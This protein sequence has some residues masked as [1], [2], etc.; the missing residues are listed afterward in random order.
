[1][2]LEDG[3]QWREPG[4]AYARPRRFAVD[5][6][7]RQKRS[8]WILDA[9]RHI[10]ANPERRTSGSVDLRLRFPTFS[11][12]GRKTSRRNEITSR[13]ACILLGRI[14]FL[15]WSLRKEIRYSALLC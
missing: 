7:G 6:R 14:S 1:M 11:I 4:S 15:R 8:L 3:H 10:P 5:N 2:Y 13:S 12:A 9:R